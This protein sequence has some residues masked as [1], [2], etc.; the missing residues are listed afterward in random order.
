MRSRAVTLLALAASLALA[1]CARP[2]GPGASA[3]RVVPAAQ[4][5]PAAVPGAAPSP[6]PLT[7]QVTDTDSLGRVL[8]D[9]GG[10]TLY[11]NTTE[12]GGTVMCVDPCTTTRH[13][14]LHDPAVALRLP[15][16]LAGALS[17][18]TRPD[19]QHQVAYNGYPL[20]TFT[21]DR[22]PGEV[23]GIARPWRAVQPR[24]GAP[25]TR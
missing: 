4:Q 7:V 10:L 3:D 20:Y 6:A 15:D 5:A 23:H 2:P 9:L 14:L 12:Q 8:A 17:L 11:F 25:R 19:G 24:N 13:P 1:G 18:V 22:Q 21:G 16:G